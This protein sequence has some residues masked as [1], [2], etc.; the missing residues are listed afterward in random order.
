MLGMLRLSRDD[1]Q[2]G[3]IRDS[4]IPGEGCIWA[5]LDTQMCRGRAFQELEIAQQVN[6]GIKEQAHILGS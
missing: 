5:G 3:K 1:L 2:A 4:I 6:G